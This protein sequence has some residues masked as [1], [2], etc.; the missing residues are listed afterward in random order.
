[1]FLKGL[2]FGAGCVVGSG[3]LVTVLFGVVVL[4]SKACEWALRLVPVRR[5]QEEPQPELCHQ[6][7]F[8]LLV[9]FPMTPQERMEL[10]ARRTEYLQ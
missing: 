7:K 5:K 8:F 10:H 2:L 1:M 4:A 9:Q 3:L 6:A